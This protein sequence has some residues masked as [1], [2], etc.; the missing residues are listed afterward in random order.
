[1]GFLRFAH[2]LVLL[3]VVPVWAAI[4]LPAL[5][6]MDRRAAAWC[7]AALGCLA[8]GLL[9]AAVAGPALR[10]RAVDLGFGRTCIV[11]DVSRSM[12]LARRSDAAVEWDRLTRALGDRPGLVRFAAS[13]TAV[14]PP[15]APLPAGPSEAPAEG[16][17]GTDLAAA[18]E[19]A[20]ALMPEGG[21][22]L[23][24]STDGRE[25]R[26]D[27][28]G[29]ARRL[30]ARGLRIDALLPDLAPPRDVRVVSFAPHAAEGAPGTAAGRG[31]PGGPAVRLEVRLAASAAADA[32]V[33]CDRRADAGAA[34]VGSARVRIDPLVGAAVRFD[35]APPAPG[36]HTYTVSLRAEGDAV[37]ENNQAAC[38]VRVGDGREVAWVHAGADP[39]GA[40]AWLRGAAPAGLT[41]RPL[42]VERAPEAL[43]GD[44]DLMVLDNV[45]AWSVGREV[46]AALI[47]RVLR[48]GLGLLVLGGDGAFGAGGYGDAPLD[49][50]LP[51]A[52]RT[53]RRPPVD[54][55]LVV[56]SSGSMNEKVG[57]AQKLALAKQAILAIRPALGAADRVGVVA[58]AGR[59]EVV[60][61]LVAASEWDALQARLLALQA[62]GGTRITPAL[63]AALDLLGGA[64]GDPT[65]V[66]HVLLLSDGRSEDFAVDR[67]AAAF[68]ARRAGVAAVAT[69]ADADRPR[70]RALTAAT[71]GRLYEPD[72]LGR[73]AETFFKELAWVRG[74]GLS[75]GPQPARWADPEPV[76]RRAGPAL[77]DVPAL[78]PTRLRDGASL[79][80]A[81]PPPDGPAAGSPPLLASWR[82]G[83][84]KVAAMPWP[85]G[86]RAAAHPRDDPMAP[87]LAD[88]AA[89]LAGPREPA[90]WSAEIVA[91]R[92][93]PGGAGA[94]RVRVT[95]R[96]ASLE[97]P[98]AGFVAAV[99][100]PDRAA[101]RELDLS[102][103]APGVFEADLPEG[104]AAGGL[105]VVRARD[106]AESRAVSLPVPGAPPRE[107]AGFG[108]DR[109]RLDAVVRAGGGRVHD[110]PGRVLEVVARLEAAAFTPIGPALVWA[111]SAAVAVL[112]L[113]RLVGRL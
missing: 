32:E 15:G 96:A 33:R 26:G 113:L 47:D 56:D 20:A 37:P 29:A 11:Q 62:G 92:R 99:F 83:L 1:M 74:E 54:L 55:V 46:Q 18:L 5:R 104:D 102:Q 106:G 35:D 110:A 40:L 50:L 85:V 16:A 81:A 86:A 25:T 38:T 89:Y 70:L 36:V 17:G 57:G 100:T 112:V 34:A 103:V 82:R 107:Y 69:G 72:D 23:L 91:P 98:S 4:V 78:N 6:G 111:A 58:F 52:S 51:V 31:V 22:L 8:T 67:L 21:G 65:A 39:S 66:R 28:I 7:R 94:T 77:G 76:W 48:G 88:V 9:V 24:L 63:E 80:W 14:V 41:V 30:A 105:V 93:R 109:D 68:R 19:L 101:A 64:P 79:H 42:P 61:P 49:A 75:A 2:P 97:A 73:L 3:L 53:G 87:L 45:P 108:V 44:A 59:P 10:T 71:G 60:S 43:A 12:A 95:R 84:G 90:D 13:V 27:A